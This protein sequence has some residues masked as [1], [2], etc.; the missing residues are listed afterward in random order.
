MFFEI[1]FESDS[2][3]KYHPND[4]NII[5]LHMIQTKKQINSDNSVIKL[6]DRKSMKK[7]IIIIIFSLFLFFIFF[8]SFFF[9]L[10]FSLFSLYSF[11]L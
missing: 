8:R 3:I 5:G 11:I 1:D 2:R 7:Y 10:S 6:N 4:S 9:S